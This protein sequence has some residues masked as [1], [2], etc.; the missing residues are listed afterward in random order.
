MI[1]NLKYYIVDDQQLIKL[2]NKIQ[3]WDNVIISHII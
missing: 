3:N 2:I 1:V